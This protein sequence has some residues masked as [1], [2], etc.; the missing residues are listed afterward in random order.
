MDNTAAPPAA[1]TMPDTGPAYSADQDALARRLLE[2][3]GERVAHTLSLA[4][5]SI[6]EE[7]GENSE[8]WK[9]MDRDECLQLA[10][11][12]LQAIPTTWLDGGPPSE[13]VAPVEGGA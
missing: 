10:N 9:F 3:V 8:P 7:L 6:A 5:S 4:L 11:A 2:L 13:P 12:L 1:P